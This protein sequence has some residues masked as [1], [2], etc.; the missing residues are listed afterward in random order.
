MIRVYVSLITKGVLIIDDVEEN[1][2]DR[3]NLALGLE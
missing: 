2:K 1:L 3:V